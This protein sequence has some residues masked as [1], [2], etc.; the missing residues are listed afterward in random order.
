MEESAPTAGKLWKAWT[1]LRISVGCRGVG[2]D[3]VHNRVVS[4]VSALGISPQSDLQKGRVMNEKDCVIVYTTLPVEADSVGFGKK[5][6]DERLA[7]CVTSRSGVQSVYRWRNEIEHSEE[8][9]IMIKTTRNRID[10]LGK[11]IMAIH[12]YEV[13]EMLVVPVIYG[14]ST[15]IDWI[16]EGTREGI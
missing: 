10:Q 4:V 6:V 16:R 13:P 1:L 8:Q 3:C 15:Y 12:P 9:E 11:R 2:T 5:L 7:A 14:D